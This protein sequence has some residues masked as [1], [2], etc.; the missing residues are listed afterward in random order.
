MNESKTRGS[1]TCPGQKPQ[2]SSHSL[3][4][5]NQYTAG[6]WRCQALVGT[7]PHK[8]FVAG[9]YD[10]STRTLRRTLRPEH[11][12]RKPPAIAFQVDVVEELRRR[13]CVRIEA[14]MP[15]GEL[16]HVPFELFVLKALPLDRGH[17]AQL[18]LPLRFWR[19][20]RREECQPQLCLEE[21]A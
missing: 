2:A 17:G 20:S 10:E 3:L 14:R 9:I 4:R 8:T 19:S 5:C 7:N 12:L 21:M 15:D 1:A 11:V 6:T 16:L 18:A 13:G